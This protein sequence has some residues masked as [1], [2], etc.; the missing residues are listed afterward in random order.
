MNI[1]EK[2]NNHLRTLAP[3]VA[4]R[5]T[6]TFMREAVAEINRLQDEIFHLRAENMQFKYALEQSEAAYQELITVID[7]AAQ[8]I[9]DIRND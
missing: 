3:H 1:T 6:A 8:K 2:I 7:E 4:Q 9:K 5:E